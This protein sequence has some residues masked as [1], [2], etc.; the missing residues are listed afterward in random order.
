MATKHSGGEKQAQGADQP[1]QTNV[2][3]NTQGL[4][5]PYANFGNARGTRE[6][7]V[8]NFGVGNN[9]DRTPRDMEIELAHRIVLSSFA[10]KRLSGILTQLIG[11]YESRCGELK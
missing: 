1:A 10:A 6:A 3:W 7:V 2:R 8:L 9:W 5:R 4:K 11:E